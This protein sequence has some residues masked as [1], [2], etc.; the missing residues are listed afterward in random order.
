MKAP[1]PAELGGPRA[2]LDRR[3]RRLYLHAGEPSLRTVATLTDAISHDTVRRVLRGDSV[4]RWEPLAHVVRALGG[5]VEEFRRLWMAAREVHT[6][7]RVKADRP[8][9][10][11]PSDLARPNDRTPPG[12]WPNASFL[13]MVTEEFAE[14]LLETGSSV[15]FSPE[16]LLAMQAEE[17][18]R[19][20]IIM[21]GI[22]K[23]VGLHT[24]GRATLLDLRAAGD[25]I[26]ELAA[27]TGQPAEASAVAVTPVRARRIDQLSFG[28]LLDRWPGARLVLQRQMSATLRATTRHRARS[29][30]PVRERLCEIISMLAASYGRET[31]RGTLIDIPLAQVDLAALVGATGPSVHRELAHLRQISAIETGYRRLVVKD[32]ATLRALIT[33]KRD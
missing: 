13:G 9:E 4:P 10:T 14:K 27:L 5:D 23:L 28:R 16:E 30:A 18:P 21:K 8:R 26:G 1:E 29:G 3:I 6:Y 17:V 32:L 7:E 15:E 24:D 22:V 20:Y 11:V 25:L 2:I 12:R 31:A 19:V 33:D